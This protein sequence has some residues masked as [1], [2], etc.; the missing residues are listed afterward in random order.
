MTKSGAM[1]VS[2]VVQVFVR[3]VVVS[4]LTPRVIGV[5]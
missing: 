4:Y 2:L 1:S 5:F 3:W